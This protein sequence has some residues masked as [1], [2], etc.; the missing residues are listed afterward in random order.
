MEIVGIFY[1]CLVYFMTI[2]NNIGLFGIHS[3]W[4]Y[5]FG[6]FGPRKI[7]QPWAGWLGISCPCFTVMPVFYRKRWRR[8]L[9]IFF[10]LTSAASVGESE[11]FIVVNRGP[12]DIFLCVIVI[13]VF[14]MCIRL[15]FKFMKRL[16]TDNY[17]GYVWKRL[18]AI[19]TDY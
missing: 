5:G 12:F 8:F 16:F 13:E 2:W 17:K 19:E 15:T 18:A 11:S 3:L 4:S 6:M 7:W 14:K 1:G 9:T 10:T